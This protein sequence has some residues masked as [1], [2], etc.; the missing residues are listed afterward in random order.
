V[1]HIALAVVTGKSCLLC[2]ANFAVLFTQN[3]VSTQFSQKCV[4]LPPPNPFRENVPSLNPS[5]WPP[6][7][8]TEPG[9]ATGDCDHAF[10][11][12][13]TKKVKYWWHFTHCHSGIQR[14][15]NDFECKNLVSR[16]GPRKIMVSLPWREVLTT[17]R[18]VETS[19][20]PTRLYKIS[21]GGRNFYFQFFASILCPFKNVAPMGKYKQWANCRT[22]LQITQ[23]N[24]CD[25]R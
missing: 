2:F 16:F 19:V 8:I 20:K 13:S 4:G 15:Y 7:R 21:L 1:Q 23:L 10:S 3:W 25:D 22:C 18:L 9:S 14:W 5:P 11:N 12:K 24:Q 6:P 17:S